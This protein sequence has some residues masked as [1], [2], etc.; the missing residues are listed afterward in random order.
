MNNVEAMIQAGLAAEVNAAQQQGPNKEQ[1]WRMQAASMLHALVHA[2]QY[3]RV[4]LKQLTHDI[5]QLAKFLDRGTHPTSETL[6][7]H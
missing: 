1:Q 7:G 2:G 6:L 5:E 4:T 3:Q